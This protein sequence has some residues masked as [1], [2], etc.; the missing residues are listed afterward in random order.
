MKGRPPTGAVTFL[1]TDVA[2]STQ[3]WERAP[4]QMRGAFSRH[5]EI[6]RSEIERRGGYVFSTAGDSFAA[7]FDRPADG[8]QAA[9]EAQ[10]ALG[11]AEWSGHDR[12]PF[13]WACMW[14]Q[15]TSAMAITS[16]GT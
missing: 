7:A 3:R 11:A 1:F 6:L 12:L 2:G 8:L 14:A 16:G 13:G 9:V 4:L 5:D 15:P 10:R